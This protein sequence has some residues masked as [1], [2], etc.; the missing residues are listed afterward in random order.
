MT[1]NSAYTK[2]MLIMIVFVDMMGFSVL[3]PII[4]DLMEYY[5]SKIESASGMTGFVVPLINIEIIRQDAIIILGGIVS[6]LW[7]FLQFIMLPVWG[8]ISDRYGRKIVLIT[9]AIGLSIAYMIWTFAVNLPMFILYRVIGGIMAGNIGVAYAAMADITS[10]KDRTKN[11]GLLGAAGGIGMIIGPVISGLLSSKEIQNI[12]SDYSFLHPFS[13]CSM[14]SSLFFILSTL[15]ILNFEETANINPKIHR[16]SDDTDSV[17]QN[18]GFEERL[19]KKPLFKL[20][21]DKNIHGFVRLAM[22]NF[23]FAFSMAGIELMLPYF[24]KLRFNATP[25]ILG[26]V[27]LY[28][29]IIMAMGQSVFVRVGLKYVNEKRL[30]IIGLSLIPLPLLI[31]SYTSE[32]LLGAVLWILPIAVGF[33]LAAPSLSG[34]IS[35]I[36]PSTEQGYIMGLFNSYGAL[37]YIFG[38]ISASLLYGSFGF[39]ISTIFFC[40]VLLSSI[41]LSLKIS[42]T[43]PLK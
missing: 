3:F 32:T 29:G 7:A 13:I 22:I 43:D 41:I 6:S 8:R 39:K 33:S 14:A 34:L 42:L 31:I 20:R 2:I 19:E 38:P 4:P 26:M 30:L 28:L 5:M 25:S 21:P 24:F 12:I 15:L 1:Q 11:M 17:S 27:F 16:T 40:I 36:A 37:A 18:Q 23:S 35:H 9:T 10:L